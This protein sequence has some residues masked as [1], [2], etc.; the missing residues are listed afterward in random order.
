[1]KTSISSYTTSIRD[2]VTRKAYDNVNSVQLPSIMLHDRRDMIL[3]SP[4]QFR[5]SQARVDPWWELIS[6]VELRMF[7]D[8]N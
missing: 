1:M 5:C 6:P 3:Q 8:L 4:V 2:A 7:K